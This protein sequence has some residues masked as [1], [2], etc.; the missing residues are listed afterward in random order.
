MLCISYSFFE[1]SLTLGSFEVGMSKRI[2]DKN[3]A[4]DGSWLRETDR[5]WIWG[6]FDRC[7]EKIS[8]GGRFDVG[9]CFAEGFDESVSE[10][11][12]EAA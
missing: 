12:P 6:Q 7:S 4:H 1:G 10:N 11:F 5:Q 9:T 8:K 2:K 3:L